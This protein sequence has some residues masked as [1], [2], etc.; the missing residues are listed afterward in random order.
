MLEANVDALLAVH[1]HVANRA[2][3]EWYLEN[4]WADQRYDV[5][6][7]AAHGDMGG[8]FDETGKH[9]SLRWLGSRLAGA[10]KGRIVFLAGC[11]TLDVSD[12]TLHTF[13]DTTS[14]S[15][16]AGYEE[17]VDWLQAVQMDLVVLAALA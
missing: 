7:I 4:E 10:C 17:S 9:M 6:Y 12:R 14:V 5:L 11:G 15:A 3:F 8:I 13:A 1:R 2:D 16:I